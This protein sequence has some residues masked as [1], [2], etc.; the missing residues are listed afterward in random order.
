M[1]K[2]KK[3]IIFI[4]ILNFS[5]IAPAYG[6]SYINNTTKMVK[7]FEAKEYRVNIRDVK[8]LCKEIGNQ[9]AI[10]RV[11]IYAAWFEG[12]KEKACAVGFVKVIK[13]KIKD[14]PGITIEA[15]KPPIVVGQIRLDAHLDHYSQSAHNPLKVTYFYS[16]A[17]VDTF[18][19]N[20][21]IPLPRA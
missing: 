13:K 7:H 6:N 20:R 14:I 4:S 12:S 5:L 16:A 18:Q 10:C 15:C 1:N 8:V 21:A 3:L 2:I 17:A 19:N 11:Q 9:K